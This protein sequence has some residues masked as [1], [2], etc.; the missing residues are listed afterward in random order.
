M[1]QTDAKDSKDPSQTLS[2]AD[3]ST[4]RVVRRRSFL[5]QTGLLVGGALAVVAG[6]RAVAATDDDPDKDGDDPVSSKPSDP[7][8]KKKKPKAK[9]TDP[10]AKRSTDPDAKKATDPDAHKS[11]PTDPDRA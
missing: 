10:D 11:R 5:S 9:H 3:I 8:K 1:S 6:V 2:D 7:D 4:E